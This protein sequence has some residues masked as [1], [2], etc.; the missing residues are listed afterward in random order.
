MSQKKRQIKISI[1]ISELS[2]TQIKMITQISNG[3]NCNFRLQYLL[4]ARVIITMVCLTNHLRGEM[5]SEA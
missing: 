4:C 1:I 3:N 2:R 5:L